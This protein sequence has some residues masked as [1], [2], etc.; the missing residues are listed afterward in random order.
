MTTGGWIVMTISVSCVLALTIF[1]YSRVL[2]FRPEAADHMHAP[3][4]I[5]TR[6]QD[7]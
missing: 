1:C 7:T 6:D 4:D 5:D 3:L 2:L